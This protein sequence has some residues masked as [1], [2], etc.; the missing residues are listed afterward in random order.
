MKH[1]LLYIANTLVIAAVL[2][3]MASF[4]YLSCDPMRWS[5]EA[6]FLVVVPPG[7][8]F[9]VGLFGDAFNSKTPQ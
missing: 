9:I 4:F 1:R 2:Y 6:R 8:L 7:F 5:H 3:G